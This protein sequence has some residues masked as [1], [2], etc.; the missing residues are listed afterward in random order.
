[1]LAIAVDGNRKHYRF[2]KSRGTDEPSVFDGLF[3]AQDSKVSAFVDKIRSQMTIKSGRDV[4]G[5]ATF[6]VCRET[7]HKSRAKVDE[8]G[9]QIAVCR[10]G[11][12]LHMP[13]QC[14]CRRSWLKLRMQHSFVWMLRAARADMITVLAM[15][16][17]HRKVENLHKTLS[18]RFVKV[19]A[20]F[21]EDGSKVA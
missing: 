4:C 10:H 3:I 1:M 15:Q 19:L 9:L 16:W 2:K 20:L 13:T 14:S 18:K 8:E 7:S 11:I 12:L 17:N 21:G 5:P 6:T